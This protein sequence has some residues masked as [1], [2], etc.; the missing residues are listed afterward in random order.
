MIKKVIRSGPGR[1]RSVSRASRRDG[2]D[3]SD[4]VTEKPSP[5]PVNAVLRKR[6]RG[7]T[8]SRL[9]RRAMGIRMQKRRQDGGPLKSE[10]RVRSGCMK[11][12]F[13]FAEGDQR[14]VFSWRPVVRS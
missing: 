3:R 7:A 4:V 2:P 11:A 9:E 12:R 1:S 6:V 10:F 13:G 8:R 5:L 14:H